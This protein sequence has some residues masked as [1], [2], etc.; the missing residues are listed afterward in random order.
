MPTNRHIAKAEVDVYAGTLL[1]ALNNNGGMDAVLEGREQY[2]DVMMFY[3]S[4]DAFKALFQGADKTPDMRKKRME[5]VMGN[6]HVRPE[7]STILGVLAEKDSLAAM[8]RIYRAFNS[9]LASKF[10]TYIVDVTTRVPLDDHLREIIKNKVS[11]DLGGNAI[12]Y[13]TVDPHMLGGIIMSAN[14]KRIDASLDTM[15]NQAR[16]AL[17]KTNDMEVNARG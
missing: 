8:P 17:K 9:L 15:L 12:L 13:E 2:H 4:H 14:D 10:N 6:A 7:V 1:D 5:E 11:A 16:S 3:I